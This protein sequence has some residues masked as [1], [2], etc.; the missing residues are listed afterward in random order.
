MQARELRNDKTIKRWLLNSNFQ[1]NTQKGYILALQHYTEYTKKTPEQLI[2]EAK[3]EIK[4]GKLMDERE[5]LDMVAGFR[6]HLQAN[7]HAPL[8]IQHHIVALKSF[9]GSHYIE[10]PKLRNKRGVAKLKENMKVPDKE[11]IRKA[12]SVCG[13][14]ERAIMLCGLSSGMGAAEI[15]TL[16]L[17]AFRDGY[18]PKTGI[19]ALEVRRVKVGRDFITFLTPE[20]SA[21]VLAYLEHRDRPTRTGR[22]VDKDIQTKQR[23]TPDSYLFIADHVPKAYLKT[24]DEELRKLK[25]EAIHKLYRTISDNSGQDSASGVYNLIRSHNMRKWFSSTLR[26]A[27]CDADLIELFMGHT[28]G[29]TKDAYIDL[30]ID[31]GIEDIKAKYAEYVAHLTIQKPLD[32]SASPEYMKIEMENKVLVAETVKHMVERT[33]L[34]EVRKK[35]ENMEAMQSERNL[36]VLATDMVFT[37]R[38]AD[39]H[40]LGKKYAKECELAATYFPVKFTIGKGFH[41]ASGKEYMRM[42]ALVPAI[43]DQITKWT[44]EMFENMRAAG[45]KDFADEIKGRIGEAQAAARS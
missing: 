28:L 45:G 15:S 3:A 13:I 40:A 20:A 36:S 26:K 19:T 6:N 44:Q 29:G 30:K 5:I 31:G 37:A 18:D 38:E 1:P 11:D 8:S 24:R 41:D 4:A 25:P 21:A 32:V 34:S 42:Y 10:V 16:T 2:Q 43:K 7:G 17:Q 23:T 33:E 39:I 12:L 9:Y 14:R 22:Q 35:L 27:G